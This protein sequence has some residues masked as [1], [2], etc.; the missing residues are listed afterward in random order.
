MAEV[1]LKGRVVTGDALY[2]CHSLCQQVVDAQGDYLFIVKANRQALYDDISLLFADP[3]FG[4]RFN[5]ARQTEKLKGRVEMRELVASDALNEYLDWPGVAQVCR[6]RRATREKGEQTEETRYAITSLSAGA[7]D[8]LAVVRGHWA[9]ENRLH[10][11]RDVTMGEDASQIR[12]GSGPQVMAALRNGILG[13]LRLLGH[14]NIAAAVR[15]IGWQG[16]AAAL[17]TGPSP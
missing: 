5:V 12:T 10:R 9:I 8:L 6:I 7:E 1:P 3:P 16:R 4:V 2:A 13:A 14:P 11:V 15:G 17:V